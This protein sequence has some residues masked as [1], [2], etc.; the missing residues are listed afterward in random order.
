MFFIINISKKKPRIGL[1]SLNPHCESIGKF[2]EDEKIII[3]VVKSL[4][5]SKY[6]ISGP[7]A[8][9]TIFLKRIEKILM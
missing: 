5:K 6:R 3:P 2:N 7:F 9:D 4:K 8:A 1:T